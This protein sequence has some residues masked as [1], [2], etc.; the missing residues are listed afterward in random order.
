MSYQRTL[1]Q[2]RTF[3]AQKGGFENSADLTATVLNG[4]INDAIEEAWDLMVQRWE[5]YY[6]KAAAL[7]YT[8]NAAAIALPSDYLKLRKLW[9]LQSGTEYSKLLPG[10]LDAAHRYT[11][12]TLSGKA[13]RYR[14][15][16]TGLL[17]MPV[18]AQ[19]ET[20]KLFYIPQAIQLVND[21]DVITFEVPMLARLVLA[22]A[23]RECLDR[24]ELDPSP[25]IAK[26][27]ELT[28]KCRTSAEARDA[29]QPFY[30]DPNAPR[31]EDWDDALEA[32]T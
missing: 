21:A 14:E 22:I 3:L 7:T 30:L 1:L 25:A 2:L 9:I 16:A 20:L 18:P 27:E 24:Q 17:L 6:T 13:Y 31:D 19:A 10:T 11:S 12:T 26:V 5:D 8:A 32:R 28:S 4:F 29:D 15:D 23:W